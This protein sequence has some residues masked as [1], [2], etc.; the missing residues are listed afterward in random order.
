MRHSPSDNSVS[1]SPTYWNTSS[2]SLS[3]TYRWIRIRPP[4]SRDSPLP[5][6]LRPSCP[7]PCTTWN[8][9]RQA[10]YPQQGAPRSWDVWAQRQGLCLTLRTPDTAQFT[11]H[12]PTAGG[13]GWGAE[14]RPKKSLLEARQPLQNHGITPF[15]WQ[16][17][18]ACMMLI[19]CTGR[20]MAI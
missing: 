1:P 13:W 6:S 5:P 20:E 12:W 2:S 9:S 14:G 4:H 8:F 15:S 10:W 3:W 18:T 16:R 19:P 17:L 7:N 11:I